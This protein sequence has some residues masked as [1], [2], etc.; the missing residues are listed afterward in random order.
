MT[1]GR[2]QTAHLA[3]CLSALVL[4][5]HFESDADP[6]VGVFTDEGSLRAFA[7]Q[8]GRSLA[9]DDA[10][11]QEVP[12]QGSSTPSAEL[13][14]SSVIHLIT[15][16]GIGNDGD[17]GLDPT[18]LAAFVDLNDA[19]RFAKAQENANVM[20]RTL[21]LNQPLSIPSWITGDPLRY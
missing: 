8:H 16:C 10:Y 18:A 21:Q 4:F 12:V 20:V 14:E 7:M 15:E 9:G 17:S 11:W 3:Q 1:R 19:E 6:I 13:P 2:T 5:F